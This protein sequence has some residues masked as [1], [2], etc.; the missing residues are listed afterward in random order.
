LCARDC[1]SRLYSCACAGDSA[2]RLSVQGCKAVELGSVGRARGTAGSAPRGG[3]MRFS[4]RG[5]RRRSGA[6][7]HSAAAGP[8]E[9]LS[10][11]YLCCGARRARKGALRRGAC[12]R[13]FVFCAVIW[14]GPG[15]RGCASGTQPGTALARLAWRTRRTVGR[16]DR[17]FEDTGRA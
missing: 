7:G 13:S 4:P 11:A 5:T 12:R 16:R 8:T 3:D 1:G 17:R 9:G 2:R 15:V 10:K 14:P 6:R